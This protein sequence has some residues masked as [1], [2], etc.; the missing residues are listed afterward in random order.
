MSHDCPAPLPSDPSAAIRAASEGALN[1]KQWVR[2]AYSAS[3]ITFADQIGLAAQ[4]RAIAFGSFVAEGLQMSIAAHTIV[5]VLLVSTALMG[6][7]CMRA[8]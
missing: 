7:L 1:T 2:T 3:G 5:S 8:R 4:R 6:C